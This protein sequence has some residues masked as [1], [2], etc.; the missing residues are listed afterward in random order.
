MFKFKLYELPKFTKIMKYVPIE[1]MLN[2]FKY[3]KKHLQK[4]NLNKN[5]IKYYKIL[6]SMYIEN[7]ANLFD[8]KPIGYIIRHDELTEENAKCFSRLKQLILIQNYLNDKNY[9]LEDDSDNR[10]DSIIKK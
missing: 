6:K 9:T 10:V 1:K 2:L 3:S 8:P 5:C 7:P 4:L